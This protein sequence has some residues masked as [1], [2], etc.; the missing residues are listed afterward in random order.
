MSLSNCVIGRCLEIVISSFSR[1]LNLVLFLV[2]Q[3]MEN[4]QQPTSLVRAGSGT[5]RLGSS[6]GIAPLES[7]CMPVSTTQQ[8][9]QGPLTVTVQSQQEPMATAN[10]L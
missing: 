6:S 2:P 9:A 5:F 1:K 7:P 8:G 4:K 3:Q 10:I